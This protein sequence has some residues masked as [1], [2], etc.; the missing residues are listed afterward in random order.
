M[1]ANDEFL[2]E[3]EHVRSTGSVTGPKD[4]GPISPPPPTSHQSQPIVSPNN[5]NESSP[6]FQFG[7]SAVKRR[8]TKKKSPN[9]PT[10]HLRARSSPPSTIRSANLDL[11]PSID[12]NRQHNIDHSPKY[13]GKSQSR[14]NS[15]PSQT[16]SYE[17]NQTVDVGNHVGFRI[18]R[19]NDVLL[20]SINGGRVKNVAP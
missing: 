4:A 12:L 5:L 6:E 14:G 15:P 2:H 9:S 18:N 3:D 20:E 7:D 11:P 17:V 10:H 13:A 8:R 1:N 16:F 19:E